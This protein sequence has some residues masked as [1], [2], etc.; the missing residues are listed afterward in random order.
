LNIL[1]SFGIFGGLFWYIFPVLVHCTWKNLA[2]LATNG[3]ALL[4][5][6]VSDRLCS[7]S[8]QTMLIAQSF[9]PFLSQDG[10]QACC[11]D[12]TRATNLFGK[13]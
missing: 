12:P 8:I 9:S 1:S 10:R 7:Q 5:L 6:L 13:I 2:T 4:F 3:A 11:P